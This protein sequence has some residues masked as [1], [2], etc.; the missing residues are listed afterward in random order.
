MGMAFS[1]LKK[2]LV[3]VILRIVEWE[4]QISLSDL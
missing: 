2:M 1:R 3:Y 4:R